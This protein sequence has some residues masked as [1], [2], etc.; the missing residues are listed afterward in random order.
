MRNPWP[1]FSVAALTG[2][3]CLLY[4]HFFSY[5]T[6]WIAFVGLLALLVLG[7]LAYGTYERW[8]ARKLNPYVAAYQKTHDLVQLRQGFERWR[9]WAWSKHARQILMANWLA[10]LLE[11][12]RWIEAEEAL[13]Q[14]CRRAS[15]TQERMYYHQLRGAYAKAMGNAEMEAQ[16]QLQTEQLQKQLK[17]R[18]GE[19]R[20]PADAAESKKAFFCWFS[21][22]VCLF[23]GGIIINLL[24]GDTVFGSVGAGL[25]ILS[26]FACPVCLS[27]LFLWRR[28]YR[29]VAGR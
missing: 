2:A 23:L 21:F 29:K 22:C 19:A 3:A 17:N 16:E 25:I 20:E 5:Q 18:Q 7:V 1:V 15:N 28:R 4:D 14:L 8:L 6:L 10:A 26:L 27:W 13:E 24:S 9:P 12:R 11:Q